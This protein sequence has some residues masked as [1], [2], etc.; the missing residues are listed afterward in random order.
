[1][2]FLAIKPGHIT[3]L[4]GND[5]SP[6]AIHVFD[7]DTIDA[8]N[9][10]LAA[11]RPLLVRGEPGIGKS[12]LAR[13]A[14]KAW[15][16]AFVQYVVDVRT[17][18]R[19]LLWHF[20]AVKRLADAQLSGSLYDDIEQAR[21]ALLV[22]NYLHPRALWWAFNWTEAQEQAEKAGCPEPVDDDGGNPDNGCLVLIDEI[23][24]GESDVPNGLLE[25]LG[26]GTFTP[27]G[28][29]V[30]VIATGVA[31]LVIITTNEERTLPDAFIRRCLVLNLSLP[32]LP[33][34]REKLLDLLEARGKAHFTSSNSKVR[35]RAAELLADDRL[36]AQQAHRS[37]LPGQAEYLDMLRAVQALHPDNAKKQIK[38]LDDVAAFTV[39]KHTG[40]EE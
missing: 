2:N 12:Q 34:K 16:R 11:R 40:T 20:D 15:G 5:A 24:K 10:A 31:P 18:S 35:R 30:P 28:R 29:G 39:R 14:A 36:E 7:R 21:E 17:E 4:A 25:A 13:A 26:A 6:R 23:D 19:D 3:N 22:E 27:E 9:S 37:P 33:D 38:T 1:M 8:I 32:A